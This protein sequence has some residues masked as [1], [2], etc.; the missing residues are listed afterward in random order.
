MALAWSL[1]LLLL[2]CSR[3]PTSP[4]PSVPPEV[5][6]SSVTVTSLGNQGVMLTA[7]DVR[8]LIDALHREHPPYAVLEG[9]DLAPLG[10]LLER[11]VKGEYA[12][13]D[14]EAPPYDGYRFVALRGGILAAGYARTESLLPL[15]A[16]FVLDPKLQP[17][18]FD[19]EA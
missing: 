7:G 14:R 1:L 10:P 11:Q 8:V 4:S 2:S 5:G 17:S 18:A 3:P 12:R 6:P 9:E 13:K 19:F 15:L 16:R